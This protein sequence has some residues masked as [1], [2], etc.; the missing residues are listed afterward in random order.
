MK[1][2]GK[3][4][5]LRRAVFKR[6]KKGVSKIIIMNLHSLN[7]TSNILAKTKAAIIITKRKEESN[8]VFQNIFRNLFYKDKKLGWRTSE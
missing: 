1:E 7:V 8:G 3:E 4:E 6:V 5:N 2:K